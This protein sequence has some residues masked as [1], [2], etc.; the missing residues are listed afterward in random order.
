[1][2]ILQKCLFLAGI[3][4]VA[5]VLAN[6]YLPGKLR[7]RENLELVAPIVRKVFISHAIYVAGIVLLFAAVTFGFA[8]DFASG[9]G[10]GRFL[11][12]AMRIFWQCRVP[13]QLF[14][15]DGSVRRANRLGDVA[16]LVGVIFLAATYGA[17]ALAPMLG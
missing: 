7:Y 16:M 2:N 14:Y 12:A 9:H 15:I 10:L 5:M 3:V 17:A 8:H 6:I 4:Q 11:A 13:L 1:M